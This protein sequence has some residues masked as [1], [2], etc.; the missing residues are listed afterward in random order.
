M[1]RKCCSA[2]IHWHY[3]RWTEEKYGMGVGVCQADNSPAFC[4]KTD[5]PFFDDKEDQ[6]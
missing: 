2:C 3:D 5:C 1:E 4:D 6:E